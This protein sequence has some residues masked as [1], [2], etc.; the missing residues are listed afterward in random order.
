MYPDGTCLKVTTNYNFNSAFVIHNC[1]KA[2]T[3]DTNSVVANYTGG[4]NLLSQ[5]TQ[6]L[7]TPDNITIAPNNDTNDLYP[8]G[9]STL[10]HFFEKQFYIIIALKF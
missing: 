1:I 8:F 7:V 10:N 9:T 4:V 3:S 6:P 5:T 2:G